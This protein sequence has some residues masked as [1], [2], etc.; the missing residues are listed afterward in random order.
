MT[1]IIIIITDILTQISN[2]R[3][4]SVI[5]LWLEI[6]TM[7]YREGKGTLIQSNAVSGIAVELH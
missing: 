7:S 3:P 4:S 5:F 2:T 1:M 6:T